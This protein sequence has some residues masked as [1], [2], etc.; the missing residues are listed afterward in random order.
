MITKVGVSWWKITA[1]NELSRKVNDRKNNEKD[2]S[3]FI[4]NQ[5]YLAEYKYN[6]KYI[7]NYTN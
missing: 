7:R 5:L 6:K 1:T 4:D 2:F 3:Q